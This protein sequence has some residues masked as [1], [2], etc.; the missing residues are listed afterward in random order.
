[1]D[2]PHFGVGFV[3]VVSFWAF[4][5]ACGVRLARQVRVSARVDILRREVAELNKNVVKAENEWR[6]GV[7]PTVLFTLRSG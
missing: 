5:P 7:K 4:C 3:P 6:I 1:M 2:Q